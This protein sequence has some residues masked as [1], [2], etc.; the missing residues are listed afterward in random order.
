MCVLVFL[1]ERNGV[2]G[3]SLE[4]A[5]AAADIAEKTGSELHAALLGSDLSD[6]PH[7]L[8]G[9]KIGHL[10]LFE[11]PTLAL[12]VEEGAVTVLKDL[13]RRIGASV[14]IAPASAR[15]KAI[16]AALAGD[17]DVELVQDAIGIGWDG[18]VTVHKPLSAG[19]FIAEMRALEEPLIVTLRPHTAQVLRRGDETPEVVRHTVSDLALRRTVREFVASVGES[20]D[21]TEARIVVA[22]GR[23][24]GG[25]QNWPV[26]QALCNELGGA[27]GA[28][29]SAVDAG[30]IH[31]SHQVGQTGKIISPDLYIA[32]GISGAIQHVAG[33]RRARTVVAINKDPNA[34]IFGICDYGIVGDL[35]QIVP[36]IVKELQMR[37]AVAA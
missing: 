15:C 17:L 5:A 2:T 8:R 12:C 24:I 31:H 28:S 13:V 32:C 36:L 10:H 14:I 33:M 11:D 21:L 29:R 7:A 20:V 26:L 34:E 6:A 37:K 27:L 3:P 22:G 30:W 16:C 18:A 19:R 25:A 1:E 4:A 35:F 23:G 9:L